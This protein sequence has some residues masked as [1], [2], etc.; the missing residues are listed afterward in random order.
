MV[1]YV[2]IRVNLLDLGRGAASIE[3]FPK[4]AKPRGSDLRQS[5]AEGM[6]SDRDARHIAIFRSQCQRSFDQTQC[7]ALLLV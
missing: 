2:N 7:S 6:A 3:G 1:D 5:T 4:Q